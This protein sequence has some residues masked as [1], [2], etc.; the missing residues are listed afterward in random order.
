MGKL[1]Q[2]HGVVATVPYHLEATNTNI[3]SI[4]ELSYYLYHNIY[5][6]HVDT[7]R[8]DLVIWLQEEVKLPEASGKLKALIDNQNSLKDIVVTLLCACD[9][10]SEEEIQILIEVMDEIENLEPI[11][12][13]KR[14]ADHYLEDKFYLAA[15]SEYSSI[16]NSK[17]ASNLSEQ[18]Y[19]NIIHNQAII[20][21]HTTS[22]L[23]A[24]PL[25]REAYSHNHDE[26]TLKEYLFALKFGK[27][28]K[29]YDDAILSFDLSPEFI[30]E[31]QSQMNHVLKE[32][33]ES[34]N[35]LKLKELEASKEKGKLNEF[36]KGVDLMIM[37]WKTKYRKEIAR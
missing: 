8:E 34:Q 6:I 28:E 4:E 30:E 35:H 21:L 14:K 26:E 11:K 22:F 25:F 2:C 31:T 16:L 12:R 20:L 13:R 10:Y 23:E 29:E 1:I 17:E 24:T 18:E 3:Y 33:E 37:D 15:Q 5:A 36:Y 27:N 32:F 7:F 9:Y 19:G